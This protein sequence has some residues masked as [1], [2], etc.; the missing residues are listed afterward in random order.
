MQTRRQQ[1]P[2]VRRLVVKVGSGSGTIFLPKGTRLESRKRWIAFFQH[3][4]GKLFVDDGAKQA[5][6][7]A[8]KSLLAKGVSRQEGETVTGAVVSICD[9]TGTEF[10]RGLTREGTVLVHRDDLVI[11]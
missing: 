11:L 2:R 4:T 7:V 8:G 5:L 9:L 6:I 1:L 3:P 10:A